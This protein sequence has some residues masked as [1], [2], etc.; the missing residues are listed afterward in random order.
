MGHSLLANDLF[1]SDDLDVVPTPMSRNIRTAR[2]RAAADGQK[3][4]ADALARVLK[5]IAP[6]SSDIA[7]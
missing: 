1:S 5:T 3:E 7:A 4:I 2:D 6:G